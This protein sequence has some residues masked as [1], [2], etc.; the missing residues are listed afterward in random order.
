VRPN[1][2]QVIHA[3]VL[4][5]E[6]EAFTRALLA[7]SLTSLGFAIV[8][9]CATSA[10]ALT[11]YEAA[12][13]RLESIDVALLDL[14]L[15]T[16]PSGIDLAYALRERS[17][18]IGLVFLTSFSDP[19]IKDPSERPIPRGARYLVKTMLDDVELLRGSLLQAAHD[20]LKLVPSS[21]SD[22]ELTDHQMQVLKYVAQGHTNAEIAQAMHVSYKA[23][24]RTITRVLEAL[25]LDNVPGNPRVLLTRAYVEL[26]GK[27]MPS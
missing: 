1:N 6:D 27:A 19:R 4:L 15:G 24:E 18:N 12:Q 13:A 10:S 7:S 8:H 2:G 14:D 21:S 25:S 26:S 17:P 11:A 5:V 23:V 3:R 16:G 20:P 22:R 9:E